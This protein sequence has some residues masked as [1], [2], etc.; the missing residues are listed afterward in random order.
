MR[1]G[2]SQSQQSLEDLGRDFLSR[3]GGVILSGGI[4][5]VPLALFRY[6]S[7][8]RLSAQEVWFVAYILGHRWRAGELP[9]PSLQLLAK[10]SGI[11][12]MTLHK[13]KNSLI[14]KG[15]L[16]VI[17]RT[18]KRGARQPNAYDFG[19]LFARLE[20][21]I[22]RD[23]DSPPPELQGEG[24]TAP[25]DNDSKP[26][27]KPTEGKSPINPSLHPP[28]NKGLHPPVNPC[29]QA[30]INR[31]LQNLDS[32]HLDTRKQQQT[33]VVA[34]PDPK[35]T[36]ESIHAL[37]LEFGITEGTARSLIATSSL[38]RIKLWIMYLKHRLA[39]G[40]LPKETPAAYLVA[41]IRNKDWE[42]P[43]WFVAQQKQGEK[44]AR[45]AAAERKRREAQEE[46]EREEA[47]KTRQDIER[48]LGIGAKTRALWEETKAELERRGHLHPSLLTAYLL[49]LRGTRG[50]LVTPVPFLVQFIEQHVLEVQAALETVTQKEGLEVRVEGREDLVGSG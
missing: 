3:F 21:L 34:S 17:E 13:Y 18:D 44:Q 46:A 5:G 33:A 47:R 15:F 28:I 20:K 11:S 40:W 26:P 50:T 36:S 10:R 1:A 25:S 31:G 6:Q 2:K 9:H 8:L 14:E 35:H 37:L 30:P 41:A 48:A 29:L 49:P 32:V 16:R 12:V 27:A 22:A 24:D 42:V 45:I 23:P 4:A 19:N 43:R 39:Q 38:G 7:E